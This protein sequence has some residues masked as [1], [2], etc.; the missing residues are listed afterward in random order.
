MVVCNRMFHLLCYIKEILFHSKVLHN[1][2]QHIL[3]NLV[4]LMMV[5][6]MPQIIY[7][8]KSGFENK[9]VSDELRILSSAIQRRVNVY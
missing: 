8:M 3:T 7:L 1:L 6:T 4:I 5:S 2:Q 9:A